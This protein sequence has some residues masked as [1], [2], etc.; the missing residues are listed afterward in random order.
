MNVSELISDIKVTNGL[1]TVAL[2]F[3]QPVEEVIADIL[4]TSVRTFSEI[5]PLIKEG[6]EA[7]IHLRSD[8]EFERRRGVFYLPES[9][10]TTP[11]RDASAYAAD[12]YYASEDGAVN[13]N[14]FTVGS[15]FV[16]FGSYYP[17]D[18]LNAVTTGAAINKYAGVTS[19]PP[20]SKW[21]GQN[22][23]QLFNFPGNIMVHFV[24]KCNHDPSCETI[25]ESCRI[26]FMKLANLDV[27]RTLYAQLKNMVNLG[28]AFKSTTLNIDAWAN[29]ESQYQELIKTWEETFHLDE[30][31]LVSFF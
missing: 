20:T 30:I 24:V 29:A 2:P 16:G 26:S 31:D 15:P 10:T 11:V 1:N 17:Q 6:N 19:T 4:Q 23:I 5:K 27:Q 8:N 14:A 21:L 25:P 18:I 28:G 22:K 3:N 7:M 12:V 9:L 13:T